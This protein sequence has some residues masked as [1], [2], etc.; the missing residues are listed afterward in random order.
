MLTIFPLG[1]LPVILIALIFRK[2]LVKKITLNI[3]LANLISLIIGVIFILGVIGIIFRPF[4]L[5][6]IILIFEIIVVLLF[7]FP[8]IE[9]LSSVNKKIKIIS[10]LFLI[11]IELPLIVLTK[12][13]LLVY[14]LGTP[15]RI[16]YELIYGEQKEVAAPNNRID[17]LVASG[18]WIKQGMAGAI[19]GESCQIPAKDSGNSCVS[20]FQCTYGKCLSPYEQSGFIFHKGVC[21]KY[22]TNFGC[23][24]SIYFGISTQALCID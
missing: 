13:I 20:G 23:N 24:R 1:I 10:L 12:D 8:I 14:S 18:D 21:A 22:K 4:P 19:Y 16:I 3:H 17:C 2:F 7:S 6:D 15:D 9:I 5:F 11:L